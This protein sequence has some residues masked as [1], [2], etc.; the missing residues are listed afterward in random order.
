MKTLKSITVI[1]VSILILLSTFTVTN[2]INPEEDSY[3]FLIEHG[4]SEDFLNGLSDSMIHKTI[5]QIKKRSEPEYVSDYDSLLSFGIP[6]EFIRGL[7]ESSLKQMRVILGNN[8]IAELD[9]KNGVVTDNRDIL[10]KKLS[11]QLADKNNNIVGETVCVYWE[12]AINKP[13]IREEDFI[14]VEWNSDV[15]CYE[16]DSFY[17]EDYR[18]NNIDESWMVS[19]SYSVFARSSL[20]SLGHWTKNYGT[21]KQVGGFMIFSLVPT[22]PI[23]S[24]FDYD[25]DVN[26]EYIH[27]TKTTATATL[28]II[29]V[30]FALTVFWIVTEIVKRKKK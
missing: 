24:A 2:A 23:D 25:R 30:L 16:T 10:I 5:T 3:K 17:A 26:I 27:E 7:S 22:H 11:L 18:R 19:E 21:K 14:S 8:C 4:F 13:L 28:C 6:E 29:F 15:F 9:Y 12:W 20:N 1:I